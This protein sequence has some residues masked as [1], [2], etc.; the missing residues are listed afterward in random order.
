MI[1]QQQPHKRGRERYKR[2]LRVCCKCRKVFRTYTKCSKGVC[3]NCKDQTNLNRYFK[4]Y[5]RDLKLLNQ[6]LKVFE[7]L[8]SKYKDKFIIENGFIKNVN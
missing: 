4:N 1:L 2:Y 7:T 8:K 3:Y 6:E 5:P